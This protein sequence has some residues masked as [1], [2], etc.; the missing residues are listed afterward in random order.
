MNSRVLPALALMLSVGIFFV[1]VSPTWSGPIAET[2]A[3]IAGDEQALIA[4]RNYKEKQNTLASARNSIDQDNLNRL[5][6]FLP[7]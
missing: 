3:S 5:S 4:A 2:K 1:Y 6:T 7:D